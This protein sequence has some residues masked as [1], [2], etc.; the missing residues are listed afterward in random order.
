M[1]RLGNNVFT[2]CFLVCLAVHLSSWF[3]P[4]SMAYT[5]PL[6]LVAMGVFAAM[7][8]SYS[9]FHKAELQRMGVLPLKKGRLKVI[10]VK[11]SEVQARMMAL[12]PLP[13]KLLCLAALLYTAFNFLYFLSQTQGGTPTFEDGVYLLEHRGEFI[14]NLT[15]AEY[16]ALLTNQV[17][18]FSGHWMLFTLVP[19]IY[20]K[21]VHPKMKAAENV[22]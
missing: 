2:L 7:I 3:L 5:W 1:I 6:H 22:G 21:M 13:I 17:R 4:L 8:I 18:G 10:R 16:Q 9:R 12:I 11:Q 20:F 19:F 15:Q 14:R